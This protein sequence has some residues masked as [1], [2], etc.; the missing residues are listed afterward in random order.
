M[1]SNSAKGSYYRQRSKKWLESLGFTVAQLERMMMVAPG[2][3]IKKDQLGADL[4]AVREG[5]GIGVL[6]VQV[7]M[8]G[9]SWRKRGVSEARAEFEKHPLPAN[10]MQ[11]IHVWEPGA[12]EPL[13][14]MRDA[15]GWQ[16]PEMQKALRLGGR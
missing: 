15:L 12:R 5:P 7:K 3:F 8:G 6:F 4:L 13:V 11:V 16:A 1:S 2:T 9:A 14:W 10:S